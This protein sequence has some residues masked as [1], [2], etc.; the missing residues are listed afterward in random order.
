MSTSIIAPYKYQQRVF[1]SAVI[2]DAV[3]SYRWQHMSHCHIWTT[4]ILF[5]EG[6]GHMQ[7][8]HYLVKCSQCL[9]PMTSQLLYK[10][11]DGK[12]AYNVILSMNHWD[13]LCRMAWLEAKGG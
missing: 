8:N 3:Q 6:L 10:V 9:K 11:T 1:E 12:R 4:A 13:T 7:M 2:M 5:T